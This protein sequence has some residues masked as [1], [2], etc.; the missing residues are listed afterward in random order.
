M[1]RLVFAFSV[2]LV[3]LLP[4]SLSAQESPPPIAYAGHGTLFDADGNVIDTSLD[5]IGALVDTYLGRATASAD[6]ASLEK[7]TDF[8]KRL[9]ETTSRVEID[10]NLRNYLEMTGKLA[11]TSY[12]ERQTGRADDTLSHLNALKWLVEKESEVSPQ[13][14]ELPDDF[15][16]IMDEINQISAP[17]GGVVEFSTF[18]EGAAYIAECSAN[19]VP[20]PPDWGSSD[21]Q[22]VGPLSDSQE[23][24]S[25]TSEARVFK[26]K[27]TSPPG[28]CIA[29]PRV[30]GN[31][32]GDIG[33]LGIICQG[34]QTGKVCFWDNQN[35]DQG[36]DIDVD[37]DVPLSEF[38][39]GAELLDGSGGTCTNCHAGENPFILHPGT[40]LGMPALGD[41][42]VMA[43]EWYDPLVHPDWPQ[44]AGPSLAVPV[45]PGIGQCTTCHVQTNAGRFPQLSTAISGYCGTI[46]EQSVQKTMPVGS[47]GSAVNAAHVEA[48][49]DMCD[50]VAAPLVRI[51]SE[52]INYGQVELGFSFAKALV[53]HNDG[54]ANL[55]VSVERI[56]PAGDPD[57]AHWD[58]INEISTVSIAPGA[59]PVVL[60]QI[61]EPQA[62]GVHQIELRVNSND[63]AAPATTITLTGEGVTPRPID[64]VL[65]LDRSGSMSDLAG[66]RTKIE[67]MRDAA[68]LYADL[69]R[70][71][72]GD[73]LGFVKYNNTNSV[74]MPLTT[75]TNGVQNAIG[76]NQLSSAALADPARLKP[77]STT[78]I[79]GAMLTAATEL[80]GP[81]PD[82]GSVMV[83]LTDGKENE[84]PNIATAIADIDSNDPHIQMYSVGLGFDIEPAKLQ[85]ITNMGTDGYHQVSSTLSDESLFDLEAF[86]FKIF[87]SATNM[88]MVTDPT[89][90]VNLSSELPVV[91]DRARVISSD[92]SATF[93]VLDDPMMRSLY[94]LEFVAPD[95]TVMTA[96][97]S[98]GGI[99]IHEKT[100]NTYRVYR[101]VFPDPSQASTYVG[102]WLL[103]LK[104]TGRWN[105]DVG[106]NLSA[107]SRFGYGGVMHPV[108]GQV[109]IGFAGA[110]ASDYNL[111]AQVSPSSFIPGAAVRLQADLTDRGLPAPDGEVTVTITRPD[112][113]KTTVDLHDDGAHDDGIATD[114]SWAS[115]FAG[116]GQAGVYEFLFRSVGRNSRGELAPRLVQRYMTLVHDRPDGGGTGPGG[117]G[118]LCPLCGSGV[119][120]YLIGTF[121][122]RQD[123]SFVVDIMNPTPDPL[124]IVVSLFDPNGQPLRC[125]RSKVAGNGMIDI[126]IG[127]LDPGSKNGVVKVVSFEPGT[128]RPKLGIAA[129]Q[130]RVTERG[131]TETS[132]H[133]VPGPV[134]E[135]DLKKILAACE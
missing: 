76:S 120:A 48:M 127:R 78:G 114:A 66:D 37:D 131:M 125:E 54:S 50:G 13:E 72:V 39:G 33:L 85:D 82:R 97:A 93:L 113:S 6:A 67:A 130:V 107:E 4:F 115:S 34:T 117:G 56:T 20:V 75:I 52:T 10:D 19:G 64:T 88:D 99:P 47:P 61:Y 11:V 49:R 70:D 91:V 119:S 123:G 3:A 51:E 121:D 65:V 16:G 92:R 84:T 103:Q 2:S 105:R 69:L 124:E 27:S 26:F 62:V 90:I 100:R 38:A 95:G 40:N 73:K 132:L 102:D 59:P 98:V 135:S 74:Y 29:L 116:T 42:P 71:D 15:R 68:M 89:H 43:D 60:A 53:L 35:N 104:P 23:F 41:L 101:I 87:A 118:G 111:E 7:A 25:Q 12:L 94:T 22:S 133:T 45:I 28:A 106:K 32:S 1:S 18:N 63:P 36:F 30:E 9:S 55:T 24:I 109:P 57:L 80:G 128:K 79:G 17:G 81:S 108:Q 31:G 122:L 126:N 110:V 86:Y 44:N 5:S 96:G 83:V 8:A 46:F 21:W 58:E 112:G 129:N 14:L 134:L 77:D